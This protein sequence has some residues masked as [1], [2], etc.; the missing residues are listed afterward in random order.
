M[1]LLPSHLHKEGDAGNS[2]EEAKNRGQDVTCSKMGT[3]GDW[4]NGPRTAVYLSGE[5]GLD[6]SPIQSS[7]VA[8]SRQVPAVSQ[9]VELLSTQLYCLTEHSPDDA[10][11]AGGC[12]ERPLISEVAAEVGG[13]QCRYVQSWDPSL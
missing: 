1:S 9:L 13:Q 11:G 12:A 8:E 3:Q 10:L 5:G 7:A 6:Y 2:K 4:L